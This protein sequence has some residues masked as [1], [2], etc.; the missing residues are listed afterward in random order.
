[1]STVTVRSGD[2]LSKIA[3]RS[4][5][6]LE[7]IERANPKLNPNLIFPGQQIAIP[8][9]FDAPKAPPPMNLSGNAPA[10]V[11]APSAPTG[12]SGTNAA[13][14]ARQFLGQSEYQLQPS[15]KLDMDK[16]VPKTVDCA[17]FVSGCLEKAG[18]ITH[19]QR[20]DNVSG[21]A[22]NLRHAGWTDVPLANAKP[23]DV[24]CFDGPGGKY[25]HVEIFNG[26][27]NGQPQFIG[28]NNVNRD[29]TQSIT[30]DNGKWAYNF[31]VL[32]A[33]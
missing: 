32:Q 31:H 11:N 22:N 6:S 24:V 23:G 9:G 3:A 30:T 18:L 28:S 14:V 21:L 26:F 4:G 10:R 12:S 33:P 25:Q 5:V 15:G 27:V 2:T 8:D 16:W 20:S 19:A 29:G 17:N 13:D 7:A 1:M